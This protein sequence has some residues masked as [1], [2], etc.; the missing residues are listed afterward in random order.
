MKHRDFRSL[1]PS[2]QAELRRLAFRKLDDG[3]QSDD[4]A[5]LVE[6]H[7]LTVYDWNKRRDEFEQN[8]CDGRKRGRR[9][10]EQRILSAGQEAE[11]KEAILRKTP[12]DFRIG[13]ALW[14]R[15]A[16]KKLI[17]HT[18]GGKQ[19]IVI[20]T[21]SKYAKRWGL[22]PQ[23]PKKY[24][25][26]QNEEAVRQ[27]LEETYPAIA[28]RAA[29]EGAEIQWS[30]E[31]GINLSAF[32]ARGYAEAGQT[33]VVRL[34]A[35]RVSVSMI[36]SMTNQGKLRFML[37]E[38][39]LDTALYLVFIKRLVRDAN[40]RKIFLIADNLSVHKAKMVREYA[41]KHPDKLELFFPAE[42]R[43]AVQ[44]R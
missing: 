31:T 29:Q 22:T 3:W 14:D 17:E 30:D 41:A 15:K 5:D 13:S 9:E 24:A 21:V 20:Q 18:L 1:T 32:Y 40:G 16:V 38:G 4:V 19:K 7:V 43:P 44:S 12:A 39:A 37:Y 42:L 26:E 23:R 33:P 27:W 10:G 6:V 36:S 25:A 11:I 34:S 8:D 28:E 2:A 35:K